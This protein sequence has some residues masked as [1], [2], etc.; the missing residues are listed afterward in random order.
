[1]ITATG[2]IL[3]D[4]FSDPASDQRRG[5]Q[6]YLR[7]G[8]YIYGK[9]GSDGLAQYIQ[10]I[11]GDTGRRA[12]LLDSSGLDLASSTD[13]SD[14]LQKARESRF[15]FVRHD[16]SFLFYSTDSDG[17]W[18][19]IEPV[20]MSSAWIQRLWLIAVILAVC[21]VLA[22]HLTAPLRGLQHAVERF[23]R[24]DF[25]ARSGSL[26]R[27]ELGQLAQTFDRMAAQIQTLVENQQDLLRDISH[28]LRSPLTRLG[29]A[30]ELAS[31]RPD[32]QEALI[33][34]QR[35]A[36]RLDT[37]VGELLSLA[38]IDNQKAG[39]RRAALRFDELLEELIDICSV[40]AAQRNCR[41]ILGSCEPL[42]I[43]ADEELLRR[44]VEN[45]IRNAVRHAPE[46]SEVIV[47]ASHS[48]EATVIRI[49][50][51]GP[52]VPPESLTRIFEPFYRVDH[53]RNRE[54]GGAGLGLAIAHR[55][56]QVHGGRILARNAHPGLEVEIQLPSVKLASV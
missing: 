23:G 13:R 34:I 55:A 18:F 56:V 28:E 6:F 7:E 35:E 50:D 9:E 37:L 44:A 47:T 27:D 10:R 14:L 39:P 21:Y 32:K 20:A 51:S 31:T 11:R 22:R 12:F 48:R 17:F 26:R 2:F 52:G 4:A 25:T 1:V 3:I 16:S 5:S 43:Q 19:F 8:R 24:G 53:D 36:D 54:T 49:R 38:R 46:D 33:T 40:E 29:L 41:L 15:V 30:V 45:V 42:T